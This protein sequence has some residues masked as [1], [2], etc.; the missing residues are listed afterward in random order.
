MAIAFDSRLKISVIQRMLIP[1]L[2]SFDTHGLKIQDLWVWV[3]SIVY[4]HNMA[5]YEFYIRR[6]SGLDMWSWFQTERLCTL[7]LVHCS[8]PD[9]NFLTKINYAFDRIFIFVVF[10]HLLVFE[11]VNLKRTNQ[12]QITEYPPAGIAY[13]WG[14]VYRSF[15]IHILFFTF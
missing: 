6:I 15:V 13:H 7:C 5:G 12:N 2:K 14:F 1:T 3:E 10:K 11:I 8:W 4:S 9:Y